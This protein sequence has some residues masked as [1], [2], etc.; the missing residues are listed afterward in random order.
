MQSKFQSAVEVIS[1]LLIGFTVSVI[2]GRVLYPLYGLK[3]GLGANI[4]LTLWFTGLSLVRGYL[5]RRA[6]NWLQRGR[7]ER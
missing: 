1:G 2:A 4:T 5:V 7:P 3:V 6:F